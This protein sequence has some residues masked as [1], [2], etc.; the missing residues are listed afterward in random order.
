[1][2]ILPSILELVARIK[3]DM[4]SI[5]NILEASV[6]TITK[7]DI[8]LL[9]RRVSYM[10]EQLKS[11][12]SRVDD[13]VKQLDVGLGQVA[14][15]KEDQDSREARLTRDREGIETSNV[16]LVRRENILSR[17]QIDVDKV[18][19]DFD[20]SN[21]RLLINEGQQIARENFLTNLETTVNTRQADQAAKERGL[22]CQE[23]CLKTRED[24]LITLETTLR[25]TQADQAAKDRELNVQ[26]GCLKTRE[27]A[28][29]TSETILNTRQTDLG[30]KDRDLYIREG[31]LKNREDTLTTL[32]TTL[33][34]TQAGQ[35]V[36]DRDLCAQQGSLEG[37]KERLESLEE[38]LKTLETILDAKQ[39]DQAAKD[40]DL[41][42]RQG[43][44]E[45]YQ[46]RLDTRDDTLTALG[47][48]SLA[49]QTDQA[50]KDQRL[51]IRQRSLEAHEKRL[52]IQE[53]A[54]IAF[55]KTLDARKADQAARERDL[56]SQAERLEIQETELTRGRKELEDLQEVL[57]SKLHDGDIKL[58]RNDDYLNVK[59]RK[60]RDQYSTLEQNRHGLDV[61]KQDLDIRKGA[62][63]HWEDTLA[64]TQQ[65]LKAR[66]KEVEAREMEAKVK[67]CSLDVKDRSVQAQEDQMR[68]KEI[69]VQSRENKATALE[70]EL[71]TRAALLDSRVAALGV[72]E[73]NYA[74][75][76]NDRISNVARLDEDRKKLN[77]DTKSLNTETAKLEQKIANC[78]KQVAASQVQ[79]SVVEQ[80]LVI[81]QVEL[82]T[83][84]RVAETT[85]NDRQRSLLGL[86]SSIKA[87][88]QTHLDLVMS[89]KGN[90]VVMT[91]KEG[92]TDKEEA[93]RKM[94]DEALSRAMVYKDTEAT[95]RQE[96][97]LEIV[98]RLLDE[99][100]A[101][102]NADAAT[103]EETLKLSRDEHLISAIRNV[104]ESITGH[105]FEQNRSSHVLE[106]GLADIQGLFDDFAVEESRLERDAGKL[107]AS[108]DSLKSLFSHVLDR[109]EDIS[110]QS[111]QNIPG[112][113]RS[114][115]RV[116]DEASS[117]D[118]SSHPKRTR[119]SPHVS[120]N[121]RKVILRSSNDLSE[122][123][124][125]SLLTNAELIQAPNL[126]TDLSVMRPSTS[127][128]VDDVISLHGIEDTNVEEDNTE[129][130]G[131]N[132]SDADIDDNQ[133]EL[134]IAVGL[135][136]EM[137]EV[138]RKIAIPEQWN[139]TAKKELLDL[140]EK[141]LS[142]NNPKIQSI[143]VFNRLARAG[144]VTDESKNHCCL[145]QEFDKR[146]M[147]FPEGAE[148]PCS[149]CGAKGWQCFYF[150]YQDGVAGTEADQTESI[151]GIRWKAY[152]RA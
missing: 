80:Q 97:L 75:K 145:R 36:K 77:Q 9:Q 30:V 24:T 20:T 35:A 72:S 118:M 4:I 117:S 132:L 5:P 89:Q 92:L 151:N 16:D 43:S 124:S 91:L 34:A 11:I 69:E 116:A 51:E 107:A 60:I 3:E 12:H 136:P 64:K 126:D 1:M 125:S 137:R 84:S 128:A 66:E 95:T 83:A 52:E 147:I 130:A 41:C 38:T 13:R 54:Q 133:D 108:A 25:T 57:N 17:A 93:A 39:T 14:L 123:R 19:K 129:D 59:E 7:Y 115:K 6:P 144:M 33:R 99:A 131:G 86:E 70:T 98:K 10:E 32:E 140:L 90:S 40:R 2:V 114:S 149:N 8:L 141:H 101:R 78:N 120:E 96:E 37:Y 142:H 68:A 150:Q 139:S 21:E 65:G 143:P 47:T 49:K 100:M 135:S 50:A 73:G 42:A 63:D 87:K 27:N 46:K 74:F 29:T 81:R 112:P 55:E 62:L 122:R 85:F 121:S 146:K 23:E 67:E 134:D 79:I 88:C 26:E 105:I 103:H 127:T 28:L 76:E 22:S 31:C 109:I 110:L 56:D 71:G 44:L 113:S 119:R 53:D 104:N 102:Q 45:A 58:K 48:T 82:D 15:G 152:K 18:K 138:W 94:F 111:R 148:K 61:T 106:R